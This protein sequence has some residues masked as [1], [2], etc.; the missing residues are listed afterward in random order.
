MHALD[1]TYELQLQR[2]HTHTIWPTHCV[3]GNHNNRDIKCWLDISNRYLNFR[4]VN[5]TYGHD[6]ASSLHSAIEKWRLY[7]KHKSVKKAV[8]LIDTGSST[9]VAAANGFIL[10][11]VLM[12]GYNITV[13]RFSVF[14]AEAQN[15][16]DPSTGLNKKLLHDLN[17]KDTEVSC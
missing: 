13:E 9:A 3:I 5:A 2:R 17:S 15:Y 11:I 8:R 4:E 12:K 6:I 7:W 10:C 14:K 1:Y 16:S